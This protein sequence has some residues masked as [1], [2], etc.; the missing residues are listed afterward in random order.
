MPNLIGMACDQAEQEL[1]KQGFQTYSL[2]QGNNDM[3]KQGVI[4]D[5]KPAAGEEVVPADISPVLYC[6]SGTSARVSVTATTEPVESLPDITPIDPTA[7]TDYLKRVFTMW[8]LSGYIGDYSQ[9]LSAFHSLLALNGDS[10]PVG[11]MRNWIEDAKEAAVEA[12]PGTTKADYK[13]LEFD[14]SI[15][16][17]SLDLEESYFQLWK[18]VL[19]EP[20]TD[21]KP[22]NMAAIRLALI[23]SVGE[24]RQQELIKAWNEQLGQD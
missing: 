12:I 4:Y 1:R 16:Y 22:S 17:E 6:N 14:L 9:V 23:A 2:N 7:A 15:D 18:H 3:V 13:Y 10:N 20:N 8:T 24:E 21:L 11:T 5:Q 19:Q